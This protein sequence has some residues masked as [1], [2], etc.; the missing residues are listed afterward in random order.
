[1]LSTGSMRRRIFLFL[2]HSGR[3]TWIAKQIAA[4]MAALGVDAFLDEAS[5]PIGEDFEEQI[6]EFLSSWARPTNCSCC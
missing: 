2:S 6:L 3:D 1:M 5:I 4:R